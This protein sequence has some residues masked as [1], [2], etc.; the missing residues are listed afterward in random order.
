MVNTVG[1]YQTKFWHRSLIPIKQ[2]VLLTKEQQ[3]L[4][5]GSLL[6]DG[7][8]QIG[9]GAINANF[10]VEQGLAQR[11]YVEWKYKIL[12]PLVSTE[13]KISYRYKESG[14]RYE[15]SWWFR[16]MRHPLLTAI[17]TE[18]YRKKDGKFK[19]VVP[20]NLKSHFSPLALAVWIM[21]D[22]SYSRGKIDMS[23]YSFTL[24]EIRFLQK[25]LKD[26]FAVVSK[27]FMDRNK[28]YRMY[29]NTTETKKLIKIICP[30]VISSLKYK[31]GFGNP[32]T[33]GFP[34]KPE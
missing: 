30:H 11:E 13:P 23:T 28:G 8:M 7:T 4:I 18:F 10:K 14:E 19:K 12:K 31:I 33:T 15:K 26:N 27:Y 2:A 3:E 17:H 32:V 1:S 16:T 21:D 22:G 24:E 5:T 20:I 9:S 6:G 34:I 25:C 29:C